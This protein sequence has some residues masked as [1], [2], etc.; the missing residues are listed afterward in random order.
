[1]RVRL[2]EVAAGQ[3]E[4]RPLYLLIAFGKAQHLL[5]APDPAEQLGREPDLFAKNLDEVPVADAKPF[6]G[7]RD[8]PRVR[9]GSKFP[10]REDDGRGG[11]SVRFPSA[12]EGFVQGCGT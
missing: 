11:A 8:R 6:G 4:L 9:H 1:M 3:G 5:K 10:E 7:L 2:V 12:P